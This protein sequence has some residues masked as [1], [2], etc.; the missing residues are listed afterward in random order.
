M[1]KTQRNAESL[2]LCDRDGRYAGEYTGIDDSKGLTAKDNSDSNRASEDW[3]DVCIMRAGTE[4]GEGRE[5][6]G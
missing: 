2:H 1:W 4:E 6:E 3:S 5:R